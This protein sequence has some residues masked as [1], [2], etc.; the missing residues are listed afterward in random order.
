MSET[1]AFDAIR[2]PGAARA[3]GTE[4]I[5]GTRDADD[6]DSTR[7]WGFTPAQGSVVSQANAI[8][9]QWSAYNSMAIAFTE[10][11]PG[12]TVRGERPGTP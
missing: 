10:F 2:A 4:K 8:G 5:V 11:A 7:D 12:R 3:V 9:I 6:E 1:Y